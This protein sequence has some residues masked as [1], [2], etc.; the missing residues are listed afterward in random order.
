MSLNGGEEEEIRNAVS[1][2]GF[3]KESFLGMVLLPLW[4]QP[5]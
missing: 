4:S 3:K 2:D 1:R 5:V